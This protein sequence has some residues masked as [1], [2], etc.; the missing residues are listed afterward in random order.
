MVAARLIGPAGAGMAVGNSRHHVLLT[1]NT[2]NQNQ[3]FVMDHPMRGA[4]ADTCRLPD[5][6]AL[7]ARLAAPCVT[8]FGPVSGAGRRRF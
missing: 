7:P 5:A 2:L 3:E 4:C 6:R 8:A 1:M